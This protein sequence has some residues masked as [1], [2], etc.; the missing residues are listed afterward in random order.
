MK[1]IYS[2][3]IIVT[4]GDTKTRLSSMISVKYC[5]PKVACE[6]WQCSMIREKVDTIPLGKQNYMQI[7]L[8]AGEVEKNFHS[9]HS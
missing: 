6:R 9:G 7:V 2:L 3:G 4:V 8:A 5:K 1:G